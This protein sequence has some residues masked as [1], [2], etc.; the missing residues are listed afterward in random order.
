MVFRQ[1]CRTD[2]WR[3]DQLYQRSTHQ[4]LKHLLDLLCSQVT[5]VNSSFNT[6]RDLGW[7]NGTE[8][9]GVGLAKRLNEIVQAKRQVQRVC[10]K[11]AFIVSMFLVFWN[12]L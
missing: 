2:N 6:L 4:N 9:G 1:L 11:K 5:S 7:S 12:M 3:S 10:I 8:I